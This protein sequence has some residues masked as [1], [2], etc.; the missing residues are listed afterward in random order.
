MVLLGTLSDGLSWKPETQKVAPAKW[1]KFLYIM[2]FFWNQRSVN[3][4]PRDYGNEYP[5]VA[6]TQ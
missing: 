6:A 3:M 2:G 4:M 1:L 5:G